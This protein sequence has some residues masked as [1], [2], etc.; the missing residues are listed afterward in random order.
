MFSLN[1]IQA[2]GHIVPPHKSHSISSKWLEV[3]SYYF[4]TFLSMH[5]P[6]RKVQFHQSAVIYVA[7]A[8]MQLFGLFWKIQITIVFQVF[9]AERNFLWDTL[10]CFWHHNT[11]RSSIKVNIRSVTVERFQKIVLPKYGHL[12]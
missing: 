12:Y 9:P 10:L 1:P 6:F 4:V 11:V 2:R 7:M 3:W 5:F 8:T